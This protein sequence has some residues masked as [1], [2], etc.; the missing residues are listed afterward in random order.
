MSAL[1]GHAQQF[2]SK[3]PGGRELWAIP[4]NCLWLK[5]TGQIMCTLPT[6]LVCTLYSVLGNISS[7]HPAEWGLNPCINKLIKQG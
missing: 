1:Q 4:K 5:E 6:L 2:V 7:L 3:L